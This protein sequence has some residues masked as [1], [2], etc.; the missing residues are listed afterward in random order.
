MFLVNFFEIIINFF[1]CYCENNNIDNDINNSNMNDFIND[2]IES[3]KRPKSD[4]CEIIDDLLS[5][6]NIENVKKNNNISN[7]EEY[8]Y[9]FLNKDEE[10]N[11]LKNKICPNKNNE[12]IKKIIYVLQDGTKIVVINNKL[13]ILFSMKFDVNFFDMKLEENKLSPC[14]NRS[15]ENWENLY[16]YPGGPTCKILF[17]LDNDFMEQFCRVHL[18]SCLKRM[19]FYSEWL[20][21]KEIN[22]ILYYKAFGDNSRFSQICSLFLNQCIEVS[23]DGHFKF[24]VRK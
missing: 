10:Y 15:A 19:E 17:D 3:S 1:I 12:E 20:K 23:K 7:D 18:V 9:Y 6:I 5:Q 2:V 13:F 8:I 21:Q 16:A 22:N 24:S 14:I 11:L 4:E